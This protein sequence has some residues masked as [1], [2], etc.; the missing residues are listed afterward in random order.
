MQGK[1]MGSA[2]G[3]VEE[4]TVAEQDD[5]ID[6]ALLDFLLEDGPGIWAVEDLARE[7]GDEV[8]ARDGLDRLKGLGLVYE[9]EGCVFASRAAQHSHRLKM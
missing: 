2:K 7:Y 5:H 4:M 6:S 1:R 8:S 3:E 9:I